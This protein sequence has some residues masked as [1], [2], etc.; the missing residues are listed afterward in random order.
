MGLV[1]INYF[2]CCGNMAK[3]FKLTDWEQCELKLE[4]DN[5]KN[6]PKFGGHDIG[7]VRANWESFEYDENARPSIRTTD[8]YGE[9]ETDFN[10]VEEIYRRIHRTAV[11]RHDVSEARTGRDEETNAIINYT[12]YHGS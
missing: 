7:W 2:I 1:N 5:E 6:N 10:A 3:V 8:G 12:L 4:V 11:Q 9:S